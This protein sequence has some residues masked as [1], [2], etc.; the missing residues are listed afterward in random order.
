MTMTISGVAERPGLVAPKMEK[1][2]EQSAP[3]PHSA[4]FRE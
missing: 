3:L 1:N 2:W 4:C